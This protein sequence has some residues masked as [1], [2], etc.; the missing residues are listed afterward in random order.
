MITGELRETHGS[1]DTKVCGKMSRLSIG[2]K[3]VTSQEAA[4]RQTAGRSSE[5]QSTR[6]FKAKEFLEGLPVASATFLCHVSAARLCAT[7][8]HPLELP[9]TPWYRMVL[10]QSPE[11]WRIPSIENS[12]S[13]MKTRM[14]PSKHF[15]FRVSSGLLA[16]VARHL[17]LARHDRA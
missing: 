16:R 9:A 1:W 4:A 11:L 8:S 12:R 5:S 13:E 3:S 7:F 17:R 14:P 10:H 15:L 6:P 2:R